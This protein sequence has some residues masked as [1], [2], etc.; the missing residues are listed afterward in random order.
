MTGSQGD[1]DG[2]YWIREVRIHRVNVCS[3]PVNSRRPGMLPSSINRVPS[4]SI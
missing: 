3:G 1:S 2:W 4:F